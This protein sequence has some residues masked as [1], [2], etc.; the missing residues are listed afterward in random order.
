M[1]R[2]LALGLA[3]RIKI[4]KD[5]RRSYSEDIKI[6]KEKDKILKDMNDIID[7]SKYEITYK[8]DCIYL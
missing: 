5:N 2:Y 4:D 3:T 7:T 1:G 8:K 6:S